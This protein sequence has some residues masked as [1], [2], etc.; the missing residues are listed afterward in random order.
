MRR[1]AGKGVIVTKRAL[2]LHHPPTGGGSH[3]SVFSY[4]P[5]RINLT[6]R[7]ARSLSQ[8]TRTKEVFEPAQAPNKKTATRGPPFPKLYVE[9]LRL[10]S[11]CGGLQRQDQ[12]ELYPS[13]EDLLAAAPG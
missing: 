6:G 3:G 13:A 7:V 8:G 11:S 9:K 2:F 12:Q 5:E 1:S 4:D 10:F